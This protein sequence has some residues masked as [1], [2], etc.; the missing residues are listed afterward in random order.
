MNLSILG[1]PS[2]K[3]F[4]LCYYTVVCLCVYPVCNVVYFGQTVERIKMKLGMQVGLG[5]GHIALDRDPGPPPSRGTVPPIFGP[6]LLWPNSSM[7]RD[8]T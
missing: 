3:Q 2:V 6:Y 8:A 7:D 4:V 1:P 5:P